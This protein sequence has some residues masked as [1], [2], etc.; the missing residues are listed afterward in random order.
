VSWYNDEHRH[1]R[2][3]FVTPSQRHRGEDKELLLKRT[4]VYEL[5]RAKDPLR[6]SG[7][8]RNWEHIKEVNLN[9]DRP[10]PEEQKEAA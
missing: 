1:S 6:W 10:V 9:P 4:T 3:G 2:I 7:K 5:A 8:V